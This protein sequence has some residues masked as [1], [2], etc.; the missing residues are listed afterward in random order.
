MKT[1]TDQLVKNPKELTLD[2]CFLLPFVLQASHLLVMQS[3]VNYLWKTDDVLGQ[4][5][6][7]SVYKARNKV[8]R[9]THWA[10]L[11]SMNQSSVL[12]Y[13]ITT[14]EFDNVPQG[15]LAQHC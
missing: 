10:V 2:T 7:A 4:G 13:F 6:T 5:A 14:K 1:L 12:S 15:I 11:V 8:R 9:W 3:T